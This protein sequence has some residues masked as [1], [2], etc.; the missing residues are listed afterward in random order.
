[1]FKSYMHKHQHSDLDTVMYSGVL[2]QSFGED[3][4]NIMTLDGSVCFALKSKTLLCVT[5]VAITSIPT[6]SANDY[7]V[8]ICSQDHLFLQ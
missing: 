8:V 2:E 1:M 5:V 7:S 4:L 6:D 3:T